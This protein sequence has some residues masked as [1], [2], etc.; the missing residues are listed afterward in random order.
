MG[1]TFNRLKDWVA[2]VLTYSDLNAEI[3]N[4]L[5]N[6]GPSGID[7]YSASVAQMKLQTSPGTLG[8]ESLANSLSG[9]IERLRYVIKQTIG[10]TYWYSTPASSIA[11]LS[12]SLGGGL[13]NNRIAFGRSVAGT[14]QPIFLTPHG[15]NRTVTVKGSVTPFVYY[16][17]GVQYT[18]STDV[19]SGT[20]SAAP[21]INNTCLV[22][23]SAYSAQEYTKLLGEYETEIP[24]DNMGSEISAL[25][26]K[27]A[28]F[29]VGT[30]YFTAFVNSATSLTK[31]RR[32]N[33]Y[34]STDAA[35]ARVGLSDNATIT[36]QRL[37]W[38][39]A[40]TDG[41]LTQ[42]YNVP[43]VSFDQPAAPAIGDYWFDLAADIWKYTLDGST[44]ISAGATLIGIATQDTTGTKA[45][46]SFD[47]F[48][49]YTTLNTID[50]E[51]TSN[52]QVRAKRPE[53][54]I[55]VYGQTYRTQ[56]DTAVWDIT[57]DLDT[58]VTESASK[59]YY[60]YIK[61]NGDEVISDVAPHDRQDILKGKY[62]THQ[63]WRAVGEFFND[64]SSNIAYAISYSQPAPNLPLTAKTAAY[65]T[66]PNDKY[67]LVDASAGAVT[68]TLHSVVNRTGDEI[69]VL[70]TDSSQNTVSV[71]P[72]GP[73]TIG[74]A[75]SFIL[76]RPNESV[77][78]F[79]DG[80]NWRVSATVPGP[81]KNSNLIIN[82]AFTVWQ[83]GT[84][85]TLT[86][87]SYT[88]DRFVI[89]KGATGTVAYAR[90]TDV[91][92]Q[93]EIIVGASK[94]INMN[95]VA[96]SG[97][98]EF[99]VT[100]QRIEGI[101][102]YELLANTFT[103]S[104]WVKLSQTATLAVSFRNQ[105]GSQ[106]YV[107]NFT[108]NAANTWE[109]KVI[110]IPA[111][112]SYTGFNFGDL[113]GLRVTICLGTGVTYRTATLNAW[114]S[115]NYFGST[116]QNHL[117]TVLNANLKT[118]LW[119]LESGPTAT[120]FVYFGSNI[121][122]DLY[123]CFRY[124]LTSTY[125][126][127]YTGWTGTSQSGNTYYSSGVTFPVVMRFAP[128]VTLTNQA[129]SQFPATPNPIGITISSYYEA[130]AATGSNNNA[131]YRSLFSIANAEL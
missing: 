38:I 31:A 115:G 62:H 125:W 91:P 74:G 129:S 20:L 42:A 112:T 95:V 24:V 26:G 16:I 64:A 84:S 107:S 22:N 104:F 127:A 69:T 93:N 117:H 36:L 103:F 63:S 28:A 83:R 13:A 81:V 113:V 88:A 30:E 87:D 21:S 49:N 45:A 10:E 11:E 108:V 79:S 59:V 32:G 47:T 4:I 71:D 110:T 61:E 96:T 121:L 101:N 68:I 2:E 56:P 19:T 6:L 131:A 90:S 98:D 34:D 94:E 25:I 70:K 66:T 109:K 17:A 41:T 54:E 29:K 124:Y 33:F 97:A 50:I 40:K 3:D 27:F 89:E 102:A 37:T 128:T 126:S 76:S 80:A 114:Q 118:T 57:A 18:I 5:D 52:T 123:A 48:K 1:A 8:A 60:L 51:R 78:A 116:T 7:D 35:L 67:V 72:T 86:A 23:N 39:F 85:G 14:T 12:A 99:V 75:V 77:S 111:P 82:G 46:R 44:F 92:V 65:T 73:E 43:S 15:T 120:P 130:R 119:K 100:A 9:E 58:G 106:S 53:G 122:N 105:G 55:S